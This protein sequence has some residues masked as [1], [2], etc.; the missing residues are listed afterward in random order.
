M[1]SPAGNMTVRPKL[2]HRFYGPVLLLETLG[3]VRGDRQKAELISDEAG[4]QDSKLRHH[5][6]NALAYICAFDTGSDNVTAL[7]LDVQPGITNVL[8][9]AN[10]G[11]SDEVA[12]FLQ[13]ILSIL[14]G[15]A[16]AVHGT[17][18]S[19]IQEDI[20]QRV[21]KHNQPRISHYHRVAIDMCGSCLPIIVSALNNAAEASNH[22]KVTELDRVRRFLNHYFSPGKS[23][24]NGHDFLDLV[25]ECHSTRASGIIQSLNSFAAHGQPCQSRF[26]RLQD[27]LKKL[28]KHTTCSRRLV[29]AAT[30]L[31]NEFVLG[32]RVQPIGPSPLKP[33]SLPVSKISVESIV[34]RMTSSKQEQ[35][36][37]E[38]QLEQRHGQS[39]ADIS[40]G[41]REKHKVAKTQIHA[42]LLLLSYIE[43]HGCEFRDDRY[44][45]CSKPA[46]YLCHL[47][48]ACHPGNYCLPDTSNK[49]YIK[50]RMPDTCSEKILDRMVQQIK[51][52]FKNDL[53]R[54][55]PRVMHAD[56]S[57]DMTSTVGHPGADAD[58]GAINTVG[59]QPSSGIIRDI[60][61]LSLEDVGYTPQSPSAAINSNYNPITQPLLHQY[62]QLQFQNP[63]QYPYNTNL[64]P[65][66]IF[67]PGQPPGTTA[68]PA[69]YFYIPTPIQPF[70]NNGIGNNYHNGNGNN[71]VSPNNNNVGQ[72]EQRPKPQRAKRP[73]W[74]GPPSQRWG[75]SAHH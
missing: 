62:P 59:P 10:R 39:L 23:L 32:F 25:K 17:D 26:Q 69:A 29:D 71:T 49:L 55:K 19:M 18:V 36:Q 31:P 72:E 30:K 28:G 45:G 22:Q 46:C 53:I 61:S 51:T 4:I 47:Y 60:E 65:T 50:W 73:G 27:N 52:D 5:F 74:R 57:A 16:Q 20:V 37:I 34:G 35:D 68:I 66:P 42:E 8:V 56:S 33:I 63:Y 70:P 48:I 41:M 40:Q 11:V 75:V 6:C 21:V 9:A 13:D 3:L 2:L 1:S 38:S 43:Q 64:P 24:E 67:L 7:A 44:I 14:Q 54:R 15:I 58:I 12:T